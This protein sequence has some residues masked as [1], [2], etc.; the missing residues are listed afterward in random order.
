MSSSLKAYLDLTRLH[1]C[2]VWPLL[3]CS[4]LFLSFLR[5]GGF[6][7]ILVAKAALIALF[8]FEAGF[9]LNDL[10]DMELDKRD[11]EP[12]LTKYWRPFGCRPLA[13]GAIPVENARTLFFVMFGLASIIA[14]TLPYPHSVFVFG[15]MVL[16]YGLE[17][18]YQIQKRD[19]DFPLAQL[20]GRIDFSLFPVA[21]YLSNGH[22]DMM[23]L[24]YFLFFY[25]FAQ[26]HLGINDIIDINNDIAR[27]L[28]T[29]PTLYGV[30][31]TKNWILGFTLLHLAAS[32]WFYTTIGGFLIYT[33]AVGALILL[34]VNLLIQRGKT[35]QDWLKALPLFHATLF[36]YMAS[37]IAN[38]FL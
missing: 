18:Y 30:Q 8:G 21:G 22:P 11:V 12:D 9:V 19:Q 24:M 10:V 32:A 7:W 6:S 33:F 17:Y 29:I 23:V 25:P 31:N 2:I 34:V 36:V 37:L 13:S 1:F 20:I 38:Y 15:I 35:P 26:T 16:S 14:F 3:F 27:N 4:G 5:Y 28:K